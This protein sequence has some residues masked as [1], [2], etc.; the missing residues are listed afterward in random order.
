MSDKVVSAKKAVEAYVAK[1]DYETNL[2]EWNRANVTKFVLGNKGTQTIS[3]IQGTKFMSEMYGYEVTTT[4]VVTAVGVVDNYPG[5]TDILIQSSS[6][7]NDPRTSEAIKI[8][9]PGTTKVK[10]GDLVRVTG[11][12]YEVM[13]NTGL[14]STTIRDVKSLK[15]LTTDV[16][17]PPLLKLGK[18]GTKI[19]DTVISSHKGNVNQKNSLDI[20]ETLDFFE[21]IEHMR[22]KI[23]NPRVLGFRGGNEDM[24]DGDTGRKGPKSHLTLY[25]KA[26]GETFSG[27]TS[28]GGL[29]LDEMTHN[30]NPEIL[31]IATGQFSKGIATGNYYKVGDLLE[32][33]LEGVF[34][35][36]MNLFGDGEYVLMTPT[37]QEL[38]GENNKAD[39]TETPLYDR[40]RT[41]IT[42]DEDSLTIA[43]YNIE[44]LGGNQDAR[45]DDLA[46][47]LKAN[48]NCPDIVNL[49]EV[50]D[51]NS[52]DFSG[53]SEA[54]ITLKK[55]ITAMKKKHSVTKDEEQI[56]LCSREYKAINIDPLAFNEGGQPGGNIRV[57]MIYDASKVTFKERSIPAP[58]AETIVGKNGSLNYNP[59]RVFPQDDAFSGSRRS[60]VSEFEFRGKKVFVIG[61][62]FNSKLGDSSLYGANQPFSSGSET[63]RINIASK[64]NEFVRVIEKRSPGAGIVVLGDFNANIDETSMQ[65][66]KGD[67][68]LNLIEKDNLVETRDR[69]TTNHNGTSQALDYIFSNSEMNK[70][71]V[72]LEVLNV[73]SDYMGRT[74]DHDPLIAKFKF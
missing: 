37:P 26:D 46:I 23:S 36:N 16:S 3:S 61:N 33:E 21:S 48:L 10:D 6:S 65:V 66:L 20:S 38:L 60:M 64:I 68:L 32:G 45:I 71:G 34:T 18:G 53:T 35:F 12:V 70:N 44:N 39:K 67:V 19:P 42:S 2:K 56:E 27:Q 22:V 55:I 43:T 28:V 62:H 4:G 8:S 54:D 72:E 17:L 58:F 31:Q 52:A 40:G 63:R 25:V 69:Y 13:A 49:V 5:G 73:N 14:S 7:D 41:T 1:N 11:T 59:G 50:Q 57:A 15:V 29:I 9:L 24:R 30:H 51:N 47:S 74:A